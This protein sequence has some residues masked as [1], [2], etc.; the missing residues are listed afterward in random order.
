MQ[1]GS[2]SKAANAR[3]LRDKLAARGYAAFV[4]SAGTVTRV[5]VGPQPSRAAAEKMLKKL[6]SDMKLEGIVV[7]LPG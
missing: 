3:G 6:R 2:F 4:K 1:L 5:Y 7:T